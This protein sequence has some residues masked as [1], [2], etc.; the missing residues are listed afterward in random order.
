MKV[1]PCPPLESGPGQLVTGKYVHESA[2]ITD[3]WI[4]GEPHAI[5]TTENHPFWSEDRQAFLPVGELR[6]GEAL[7]TVSGTQ[8]KLL[9]CKPRGPPETVYNLEVSGTHTYHIGTTGVWVH[10]SCLN[11]GGSFDDLKD[12]MKKTGF[13]R[14]LKSLTICHKMPRMLSQEA[15]GQL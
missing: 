10:N 7:R 8:T 3:V 1:E 2:R 15:G 12:M 6:I 14:E 11:R 13:Q 9:A 5:G 4:E